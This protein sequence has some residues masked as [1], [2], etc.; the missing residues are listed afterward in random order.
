[1]ANSKERIGVA[2]C[3][4]IAER[5]NWM[6]R[7]QPVNDIGIDAYMES[8][9]GN[10]KIEQLLAV[11]IKSGPSFF[12]EEKDS[13]VIFRDIN[14][15]QY[16]YWITHS[17]PCILVLY[18]PNDNICIWEKLTDETIRKTGKGYAVSV[19]KSQV[20]LDDE[21]ITELKHF[22][23]LPEFIV[24]FNFLYSQLEFMKIIDSGGIVKLHA[25][26]WVNKSIGRGTIK[27]IVDNQDEIEEYNY[28]YW[29]P[30]ALYTDVF[31]KLFPWAEFTADDEFYEDDDLQKWRVDNC[32]YDKETD[33]WECY[34]VS[35]SEFRKTLDPIRAI[36]HIGEVDEYMLILSLNE[37]GRSFL[38]VENFISK[39]QSYADA[40]PNK[41]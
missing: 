37:L 10:G 28:P 1:M 6:F 35:F 18:N 12:K 17:L 16:N 27:L 40:R 31:K 3:M 33:K 14:E 11:Q 36:D 25:T 5:N 4:E 20:F 22:S 13:C 23:S 29:F 26:E 9:D 15:R 2:H 41:E 38:Y 24:N 34:G 21:S 30:F 8:V 7:E 32:N 39:P 19:P